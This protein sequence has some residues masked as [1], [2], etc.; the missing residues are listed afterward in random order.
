MSVRHYSDILAAREEIVAPPAARACNDHSFE[1]PSGLYVATA[2]L[3][4]GFVSVL[5]LSFMGPT[6]VIPYAICIAFI[7]AFFAVPAIFVR[8]GSAEA[9]TKPLS[10]SEYRRK[11]IATATGHTPAGEATTLV[12]LLPFLIM[13]WAVAVSTIAALN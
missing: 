1:L 4:F 5:S 11:G 2:M 6:M 9:Q 12:L 3:L 7:A 8:T 10:W 13:C